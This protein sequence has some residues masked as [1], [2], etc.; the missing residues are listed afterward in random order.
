MDGLE[1]RPAMDW[2]S[3]KQ[4]NLERMKRVLKGTLPF[5]YHQDIDLLKVSQG[6][7]SALKED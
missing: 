7:S 6:S 1:R 5:T 3:G 4:R 2:V